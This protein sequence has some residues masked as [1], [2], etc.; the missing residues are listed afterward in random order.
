MKP[1]PFV[2]GLLLAAGSSSRF[3]SA[4]QL[5]ELNGLTLVERAVRMLSESEV[6]EVVVVLGGHAREVRKKVSSG[7]KARVVVNPDY[8]T[9]LSSSLRAGVNALDAGS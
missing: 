9:G 4:K 8:R 2:S 7:K 6:D 1:R 3:G 5:A